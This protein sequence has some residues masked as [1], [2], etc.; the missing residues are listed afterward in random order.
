VLL[1]LGALFALRPATDGQN[2]QVDA[3]LAQ[4]HELFD[5]RGKLDQ[6]IEAYQDVLRSDSAN[7]EAHTR[8]AL[9]YQM[10]ARYSDAETEARAAIDADNRAVLA[11][12]VLA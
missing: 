4:A 10:R 3:A 11:H 6:A 8:L 1:A 5:Q 2:R 9:I 12:A 7:T